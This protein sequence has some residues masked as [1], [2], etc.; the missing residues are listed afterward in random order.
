MSPDVYTCDH[1]KIIALLHWLTYL[2][3]GEKYMY[4]TS[5]YISKVSIIIW[6]ILIKLKS[7]RSR[8]KAGINFSY[9]QIIDSR[10]KVRVE[11]MDDVIN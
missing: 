8:V 3:W 7:Y 4:K 1:Y 9:Q 6:I 10:K 11:L 5:L 2:L